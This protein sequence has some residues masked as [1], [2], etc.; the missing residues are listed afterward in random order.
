LTVSGVIVDH[1]NVIQNLQTSLIAK[2]SLFFTAPSILHYKSIRNEL[3]LTAD[4]IIAIHSKT[5][6]P[7]DISEFSFEKINEAFREVLSPSS[8]KA[9]V[10][11]I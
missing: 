10:L 1:L 8:A 11:K 3:V 2:K 9:V 5:P 4:E 7:C 6:F